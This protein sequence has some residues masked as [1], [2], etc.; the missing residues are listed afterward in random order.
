MSDDLEKV[1]SKIVMDLMLEADAKGV[2]LSFKDI[3]TMVGIPQELVIEGS[4]ADT[5]FTLNDEFI[6]AL[7]D[8]D[9]RD[10]MIERSFSTLH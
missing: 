8:K 1:I 10:A 5:Y 9:L 7:N 4:E 6:D 2:R 3:C